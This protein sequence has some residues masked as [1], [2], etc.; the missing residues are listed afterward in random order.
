MLSCWTVRRAWGPKEDLITSIFFLLPESCQF[1][2]LRLLLLK[3][4]FEWTAIVGS[5]AQ[6]VFRGNNFCCFCGDRSVLLSINFIVDFCPHLYSFF[7]LC[8]GQISPL[9]IFRWLTTTSDRNAESCNCIPSNSYPKSR[10]ITWRQPGVKFG[11]N[12]VRKTTKNY[13]DEDKSPQ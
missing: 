5:T 11:W 2:S 4:M 9:A 8:F 12:V 1:V 13:Q 6:E 7:S 3:K 10:I